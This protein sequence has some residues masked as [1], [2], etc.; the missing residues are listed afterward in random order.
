MKEIISGQLN[1][2]VTHSLSRFKVND[3]SELTIEQKIS[4]LCESICFTPHDL[5]EIIS[6]NSPVLRTVKGHCFEQFFDSVLEDMGVRTQKVGGDSGVDRIVNSKTLQLK[7]PTIAGTTA[8]KIQYKTHK[9]HGAKSETESMEYYYSIDEFAD[10]LVG[11]ISYTPL[12]MLILSK[13][14]LPRHPNDSKKIKSPFDVFVK[15]NPA[16]N[17]FERL[18]LDHLL[19][20]NTV[21]MKKSDWLPRTSEMI[22]VPEDIIVESLFSIEN[23]RIWDMSIRGFAREY[24]LNKLLAKHGVAVYHPAHCSRHRADKSDLALM[25]SWDEGCTHFQVKGVTFSQCK[26]SLRDPIIDIET[27]LSRGRVN[28]HPTQSRLYL[29]NDFDYLIVAVDPFLTKHLKKQFLRIESEPSWS[30][31]VINSQDL[32]KHPLYPNRVKSHQQIPYSTL[33]KYEIKNEWFPKWRQKPH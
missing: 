11:L 13:D 8:E 31:Y 29:S 22:G 9:T 26:L 23:F 17:A 15:N 27:Q 16:L 33:L 30:F 20:N 12:N 25:N 3:P 2:I 1:E 5:D 19:P 7:T 10:Y 6:S 21:A 4:S 24:S 14:E 18:G 32:S 28:D